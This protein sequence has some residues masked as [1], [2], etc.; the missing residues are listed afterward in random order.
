MPFI[1][2]ELQ[3]L[4]VEAAAQLEL[5][6]LAELQFGLGVLASKHLAPEFGSAAPLVEYALDQEYAKSEIRYKHK[7]LEAKYELQSRKIFSLAYENERLIEVSNRDPL[8][9]LLNRRGAELAYQSL[10]N[11]TTRENNRR[12]RIGF[13][14]AEVQILV[15]DVDDFKRTND[16]YGHGVGDELLTHI[17]NIMTTSTRQNHAMPDTVAR[18]G[19][20]EFLILMYGAPR[21]RAD[22]TANAIRDEVKDLSLFD[23]RLR[24]SVSIGVGAVNLAHSLKRTIDTADQALLQAKKNG[25][26]VVVHFDDISG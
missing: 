4:N 7:E 11:H 19:G 1:M 8:T 26:N 13:D 15:V 17:A 20:D 18:I 9:G 6:A 16:T 14:D 23:K 5:P 25:K 12:L 22:D 3:P 21:D 10:V 2:K 24:S